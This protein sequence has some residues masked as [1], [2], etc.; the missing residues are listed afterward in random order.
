M[1]ISSIF[2]YG[3]LKRDQLRGSMWPKRP[4]SIQPAIVLGQ[5]WDLGSYPGLCLGNDSIL[6]ELWTF[7][8]KDI[9]ATLDILD[10]IEGYDPSSASG[11][12]LRKVIQVR[13][14]DE[15]TEAFAYLIE[16]IGKWPRAR[17]IFPWSDSP[18]GEQIA[19]WPDSL[20]RV[21]EHESDE[22]C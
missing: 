12:Y 14:N 8:S 9:P 17:R 2:V 15:Q 11:L 1:S 4:R 6:G 7:D 18:S 22:D 13:S 21:P 10:G 20:A 5:L 19:L 16:D 3:T